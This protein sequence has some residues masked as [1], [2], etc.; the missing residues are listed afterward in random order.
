MRKVLSIL[1]ALVALLASL[2][3]EA[4]PPKIEVSLDRQLGDMVSALSKYNR[5]VTT[6]DDVALGPNVDSACAASALRKSYAVLA[7]TE[8][9]MAMVRSFKTTL[10]LAKL[11]LPIGKLGDA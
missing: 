5:M 4:A 1:V 8:V 2:R 11:A 6:G 7:E 10:D 9:I 3:V